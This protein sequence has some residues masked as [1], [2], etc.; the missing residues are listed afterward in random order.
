[1]RKLL[2]ALCACAAM[3]P[4]INHGASAGVRDWRD[5]DTGRVSLGCT[6]IPQANAARDSNPT[7]RINIDVEFTDP[8][9]GNFR[10]VPLFS[11]L[12]FL[13]NG[14]RADRWSQYKYETFEFFPEGKDNDGKDKPANFIFMG[15]LLSNPRQVIGMQLWAP[16]K[17]SNDPDWFYQ[18]YIGTLQNHPLAVT[19]R[20]TEEPLHE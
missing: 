20:C 15:S 16:L 13:A 7:V 8:R 18:E 14:A 5:N 19:A 1:M 17:G 3:F 6:P 11:A 9:T 10:D 4:A 12:H 2:I